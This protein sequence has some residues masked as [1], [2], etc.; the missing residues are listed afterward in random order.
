MKGIGIVGNKNKILLH[1]FRERET[2][3]AQLNKYKSSGEDLI[4]EEDYGMSS[5]NESKNVKSK[6][7]RTLSLDLTHSIGIKRTNEEKGYLTNKNKKT[8]IT[9]EE[10]NNSN[11]FHLLFKDFALNNKKKARTHSIAIYNMTDCNDF[12]SFSINSNYNNNQAVI[13]STTKESGNYTN[14]NSSKSIFSKK[15][16][17][18]TNSSNPTNFSNYLN[19]INRGQKNVNTNNISKSKVI[20]QSYIFNR[21]NANNTSEMIHGNQ[22]VHNVNTTQSINSNYN[23]NN[24]SN[25]N[26]QNSKQEKKM[27]MKKTSNLNAKNKNKVKVNYPYPQYSVSTNQTTNS[28][29][30]TSKNTNSK[31]SKTNSMLHSLQNTPTMQSSSTGFISN[32]PYMQNSKISY[33]SCNSKPPMFKQN[34]LNISQD[35]TKSRASKTPYD[36]E[37][38]I[39][40]EEPPMSNEDKIKLCEIKNMIL[41][42]VLSSKQKNL[43]LKELENIYRYV[44]KVNSPIQSTCDEEIINSQPR[45]SVISSSNSFTNSYTNNFNALKS[46]KRGVSDKDI[47]SVDNENETLKKENESL[48]SKME[49]ID[50]KFDLICVE[51]KE[52]KKYMKEKTDNI[53]D[54]RNILKAFQGELNEMKKSKQIGSPTVTNQLYN[55]QQI[56]QKNINSN[57][58]LSGVSNTGNI[59]SKLKLCNLGI[60]NNLKNSISPNLYP[61]N[62]NEK[63]DISMD[64]NRNISIDQIT[65]NKNSDKKQLSLTKSLNNKFSFNLVPKLKFENKDEE[66]VENVSDNEKT[67]CF[68]DIINRKDEEENYD[69]EE[70]EAAIKDELSDVFDEVSVDLDCLNR[71][72]KYEDSG[73]SGNSGNKHHNATAIINVI[74]QEGPAHVSANKSK[75]K[76]FSLNFSSLP[77]N[78]FNDEFLQNYKDFSP[79]WR[80]EVEKIPISKF[81]F[82][83]LIENINLKN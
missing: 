80:K 23:S 25:Y 21:S 8:N 20:N 62:L 71:M 2:R 36:E 10:E 60:S 11:K 56:P 79:S 51:N 6:N 4:P 44:L 54:L 14:S 33:L 83:N 75:G 17:T 82:D 46:S 37:M 13:P 77:R 61:E 24:N 32:I 67:G 19:S 52:L 30:Y 38:E 57:G 34:S 64:D 40:E 15:S 73:N 55:S 39:E 1:K 42:L 5:M 3:E 69:D 65:N 12:N 35:Y 81:V 50:Q 78:D 68:A 18:K 41:E 70:D 27:L 29:A 72:N 66:S 74:K 43:I 76:S 45:K 47:S 53:D 31:N 7:S 9:S 26:A 16:V 59:L 28:G 63:Q 58:I 22:N 49:V 48:K